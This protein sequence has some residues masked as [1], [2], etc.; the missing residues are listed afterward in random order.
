MPSYRMQAP[1]KQITARTSPSGE[2]QR[3]RGLETCEQLVKL[4]IKN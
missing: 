1:N 4:Q 2:Y 3:S